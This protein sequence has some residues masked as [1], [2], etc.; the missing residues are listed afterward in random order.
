M[1]AKIQSVKTM[2]SECIAPTADVTCA[3][4]GARGLIEAQQA[5]IESIHQ[6]DE[7][8]SLFLHDPCRASIN[9]EDKNFF[10][11]SSDQP[12]SSQ[13]L[14]G[15]MSLSQVWKDDR[16]QNQ[17]FINHAIRE[18]QEDKEHDSRKASQ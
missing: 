17:T 3:S 2:E 18:G 4:A 5:T 7:R 8:P 15:S 12:R 13:K 11:R 10:L 14:E 6:F 9:V 16:R 1:N